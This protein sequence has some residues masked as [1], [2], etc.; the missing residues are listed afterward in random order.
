M[1]N[2]QAVVAIFDIG[3]TNKKLLLFNAQYQVVH[4]ISEKFTE[5]ADADGFPSEN[6]A[7]VLA[8][9]DAQ[10]A[11]V[12]QD[13]RW[14]LK[15]LNFSAY[16]ASLVLVDA[17]GK[18]PKGLVNYLKPA[19]DALFEQFFQ[20]Y[21]PA[22]ELSRSSSSPVL[23]YLNSAYQAYEYKYL[24]PLLWDQIQWIFHWPNFLSFRLHGQAFA[25]RTSIGCHTMMWDFEAKTYQAWVK[26]E[27]LLEKLPAI[28]PG[29]DVIMATVQGQDLPVGMG[30]H[31][32]SSALI[33]YLRQMDQPFV[34]ISTGTWCISMNPFLDSPLSAAALENDVLTFL[35]MDGKP[36]RA[37]RLFA[38]NEHEQIIA[39]LQAHF[40]VD[41]LAHTRVTWKAA[42]A[43]TFKQAMAAE[44]QKTRRADFLKA[45]DFQSKSLEDFPDFESAYVAFVMDLVFQQL[46]SLSWVYSSELSWPILVDGG[47]SKNQVYMQCLALAFPS[48]SVYAAEV[49]QASSLGA[50]LAVHR[51]WNKAE[52]PKALVQM[53]LIQ[54]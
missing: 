13:A 19:N 51:A 12:M 25:E 17:Q 15:A 9:M 44:A 7:D 42:Y 49:A 43:E 22:E 24:Y 36:V 48:S 38:G 21:G 47:F 39:R 5:Q 50:A 34:L 54:A 33:P 28:R 35:Q 31:D 11:A 2:Q 41:A 26:A 20:T 30:L 10:L 46:Y 45:S 14:S 29:D 40:K 3:K 8:W 6:L 4:Q 37:A 27:G 1:D 23:A 52:L 16:G 18:A 53:N 32:S